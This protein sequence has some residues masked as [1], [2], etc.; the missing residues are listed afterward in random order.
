M[1]SISWATWANVPT[2]KLSPVTM[3]AQDKLTP[4]TS[5]TNHWFL[6][7]PFEQFGCIPQRKPQNDFLIIQ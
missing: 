2:M 1:I 4:N 3:N 7:F 6:S 5:A